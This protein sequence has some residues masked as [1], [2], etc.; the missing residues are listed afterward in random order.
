MER[1]VRA[2]RSR[3]QSDNDDEGEPRS[4]RTASVSSVASSESSSARAP[5]RVVATPAR[6]ESTFD[7]FSISNVRVNNTTMRARDQTTLDD[8]LTPDVV[9]EAKR[10]S[11]SS[12]SSDSESSSFMEP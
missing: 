3:S 6:H 2:A 8:I 4:S 5:G 10:N 12:K 11:Q 7:D 9:A 1:K